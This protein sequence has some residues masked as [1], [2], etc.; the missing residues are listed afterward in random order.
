M[1]GRGFGLDL[2]CAVAGR[3]GDE[4]CG[5]LDPLINAGLISESESEA[6]YY[7]SHDKLRQTL[8]EDIGA[9][10]RREL[11]LR[12]AGALASTGCEPAELAHHYLQ[13][14]AWPQALDSLMRAARRAEESY[15][16]ESALA[17][18]ARALE[19]VERVPDPEETKFGLQAA[20]EHLLEH[21]DRREERAEAVEEM[22]EL[23]KRLGEKPRLAEV[24][25][26]RIGVLMAKPDPEGA[27]RA[28]AGLF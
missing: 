23:A 13:T 19:V 14:R 7:F 27:A 20:R 24:H 5:V 6:G 2:L 1:I 8:Y 4:V 12:V 9:N 22:Y 18:Y 16:W 10:R 15:A 11:H 21:L 25:I 26:R 3:S 28:L 17:D